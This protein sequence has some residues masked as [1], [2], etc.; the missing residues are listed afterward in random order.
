V[1]ARAAVSGDDVHA[2]V[3]LVEN[4]P[5]LALP[6]YQE[7]EDRPGFEADVAAA[8]AYVSA[9]PSSRSEVLGV[10]AASLAAGPL[11]SPPSPL[12][13]LA[14]ARDRSATPELAPLA[15][16]MVEETAPAA[17]EVEPVPPETE[18]PPPS[19]ILPPRAIAVLRGSPPAEVRGAVRTSVPAGVECP[20][21]EVPALAS[22]VAPAP[23]DPVPFRLDL[24]E[25]EPDKT[26]KTVTPADPGPPSTRAGGTVEARRGMLA[27][28]ALAA[29]LGELEKAFRKGVRLTPGDFQVWELPNAEFD[30]AAIPRP[31]VSVTGD[32]DSAA[33]S[34]IARVVA[35]DRGG[36]VLA[37]RSG[38]NVS[39]DLPVGA[40]RLVLAGLGATDRAAARRGSGMSGWHAGSPLVQATRDSYLAAGA[41]VNATSPDTTRAGQA[42]DAAIVR[43]ADATAGRAVVATRFAA[44]VTTVVIAL[45]T[46]AEIDELLAGL[47]MGLD[48]AHR[49]DGVEV[50]PDPPALIVSGARAYAIFAVAP[51]TE[52]QAVT[53]TVAS[54]E[55]WQLAGVFAAPSPKDE[56]A[57]GVR[58]EGLDRLIA[59]LVT[60]PLGRST[61]KW[62][63]K[64]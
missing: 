3:N 17:V 63:P 64:G 6:F 39:L 35:L 37:D 60:S 13:Q 16:G 38:P 58:S 43:A 2:T 42:V 32:G 18:E 9:Q 14:L 53:V 12:A 28:S 36:R 54:D 34:Q 48:G 1:V 51:D 21:A 8:Q 46:S 49:A 47:V 40:H 4:G 11:A 10:V 45:E 30:A 5:A 50:D 29:S 7:I 33:G 61:A 57:R 15:L 26:D 25:P 23:D 55:R 59:P 56:V 31:R 27:N 41:V 44:P 52:S 22:V 20:H 24:V 19:A 62:T